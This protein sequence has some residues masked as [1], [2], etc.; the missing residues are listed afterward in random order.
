L[1]AVS[2]EPLTPGGKDART[3]IVV[4]LLLSVRNSK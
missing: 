1:N 3:W 4:V 2:E